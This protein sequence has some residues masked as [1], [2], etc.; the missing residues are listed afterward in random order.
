MVDEKQLDFKTHKGYF[1]FHP[2][3]I[4]VPKGGGVYINSHRY[5]FTF[6]DQY[7]EIKAGRTTNFITVPLTGWRNIFINWVLDKFFSPSDSRVRAW[8]ALHDEMVREFLDY[9]KVS[10]HS[11]LSGEITDACIDWDQAATIMRKAMAATWYARL[12]VYGLVR[13]Y[14]FIRDTTD[15]RGVKD[16]GYPF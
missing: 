10:I 4:W 16:N 6:G 5:R 11:R 8:A 1:S 13:S 9:E 7:I 15:P 2:E 14:G 3:H 12:I